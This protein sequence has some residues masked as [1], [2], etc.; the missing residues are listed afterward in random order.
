MCNV[1][2]QQ[3]ACECA[4]SV[5]NLIKTRVRNRLGSKNLKAMLQMALKGLDDEVDNIINDA[6]PIWKN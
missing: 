2:L 5:Q 3:H 6:I 1:F 4:F